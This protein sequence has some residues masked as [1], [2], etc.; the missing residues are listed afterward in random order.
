MMKLNVLT[1]FRTNI[2]FFFFFFT[3][4]FFFCFTCSFRSF[5]HICELLCAIIGFHCAWLCQ[6]LSPFRANLGHRC[7]LPPKFVYPF[8]YFKSNTLSTW[9]SIISISLG[10]ICNV[11]LYFIP[12]G[13]IILV[14]FFLLASFLV[15]R[16][17]GICFEY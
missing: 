13:Q 12:K 14:S 7:T 11:G 17:L 16:L 3:L 6:L 15:D 5:Q 4:F 2:V 8:Q 1:S 10:S 9:T